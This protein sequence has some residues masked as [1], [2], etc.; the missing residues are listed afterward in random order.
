MAEW[1]KGEHAANGFEPWPAFR[2]RVRGALRGIMKSAG[3]GSRV[4]VFTSGGPIG[5][6]VQTALAAPD[7]TAI[8]LNWR[9]RNGSVT[10]FV[11]SGGRVTLDAYNSIAHL[12]EPELWTYR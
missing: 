5:V 7:P 8:E 6:A 4:A 10:E 12:R 2:D 9:V 3:G 1:V 11:F